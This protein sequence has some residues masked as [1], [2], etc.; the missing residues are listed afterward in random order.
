VMNPGRSTG[1]VAI[2]VQA[3]LVGGGAPPAAQERPAVPADAKVPP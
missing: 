1:A 3:A 2:P